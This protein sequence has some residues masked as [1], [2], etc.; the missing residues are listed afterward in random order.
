MTLNGMPERSLRVPRQAEQLSQLAPRLDSTDGWKEYVQGDLWGVCEITAA[1]VSRDEHDGRSWELM[2]LAFRDLS[3]SKSAVHAFEQATLL[4]PLHPLSQICLAECHAV[5]GRT[6]LARDLYLAQVDSSADNVDLLLLVAA[7]LEGIDEPHLAMEVC[8]KAGAVAPESAQV[9]YDMSFYAARCGSQASLVEAL[10]WRAVELE[11]RNVHFRVG[12][13]SLLIR[14]ER[15]S[16]AY[17][18]VHTLSNEQIQEVTCKCCLER[19]MRLY[20][21]AGDQERFQHCETRLQVLADLP[22]GKA[23]GPG[24][25]PPADES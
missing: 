25:P 18:V 23:L 15:F 14:L 4:V 3:K 11:P 24:C 16:K 22:E 13:A 9:V 21:G 6:E 2:G 8:R 20:L 7:G 12:L 19:I 1:T 17:W 10:A 5:L